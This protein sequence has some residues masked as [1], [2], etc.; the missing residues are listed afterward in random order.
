[1]PRNPI[2]KQRKAKFAV[3]DRLDH[4][5]RSSLAGN[6]QIESIHQ[7]KRVSGGKPHPL[8]AVYEGMIVDQRLQQ[9]STTDVAAVVNGGT[10]TLYLNGNKVG[11]ASE[12]KASGAASPAINLSGDHGALHSLSLRYCAVP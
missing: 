2:A 9:G 12:T 3:R 8:V 6:I 5:I 10:I 11:Q 4:K 1:M 7:Q